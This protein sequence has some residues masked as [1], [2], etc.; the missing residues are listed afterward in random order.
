MHLIRSATLTVKDLQRSQS[1]YCQWLGYKLVEQ[2]RISPSL[3]ISW[4]AKKTEGCP[5]CILQPASNA[6]VYI[7]L[8]EQPLMPDYKPLRT[9]GWAAI[10]ICNQDTL[11]VNDI[12][13][14]S[15]FEII[16]PP[17]TLDGIPEIFPMQVSGPDQEIVYLTEIRGNLKDYDLPRAESLIDKLFILVS[18]CSDIEKTSEWLENHILVSK[19]Q[20][21]KMI[22]SMINKSFNLPNDTKHALMT[23]QHERDVFLQIDSYPDAATPRTSHPDMLPPC[24][25][26]GSFVHPDFDKLAEINKAHWITPPTH[27]DGEIYKG[28]RAATLRDPDGT[29]IELIE[30]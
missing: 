29:L 21:V 3:A 22:Y 14:K 28:K 9:Y 8:I 26:I 6:P 19:G 7:R 18:A 5:Y 1:D 30:A 17:K 24:T 11:A 10:E 27:R 23:L 15:P 4:G 25:A 12:M 13:D 20:S 2:G 16:G